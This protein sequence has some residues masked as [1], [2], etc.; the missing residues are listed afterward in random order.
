LQNLRSLFAR[1][2]IDIII[3][4][5][6][7]LPRLAQGGRSAAEATRMMMCQIAELLP[8]EMRGVYGVQSVMAAEQIGPT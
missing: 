8:V 7:R 6:L 3:G 5:P 2:E 4:E 1:R